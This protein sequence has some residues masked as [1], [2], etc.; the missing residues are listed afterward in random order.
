MIA[1]G[2]SSASTGNG[3]IP[4]NEVVTKLLNEL[5]TSNGPGLQY[6]VVDKGSIIFEHS[7]GLSD[8]EQKKPL[9]LSQTM[10]AFSMTKTLTAIAVLQLIEHKKINID[11]PV[12]EYFKHPYNAE[13]TI[14]QLLNHTSGIPNPIP[15]KWVHLAENHDIFDEQKALTQVLKENPYSDSLP[16]TEYKY[17]NIGYWL[18]GKVIEKASGKK[19]VDYVTENIFVLLGLTSDEIGFLIKSMNNHAKGYVKKWSFMNLIGRFL[20]DGSVFGNDEGGWIHTKNVYLNGPSFGGTV[21]SARAFSRIL[22]DL[23]SEKSEL[24]GASVKQMLYSQQKVESGKKIDMT[25]GWH[26]GQ[27]NNLTYYYKEG[28]G[29]GFSS[30]MRIY[31]ESGLASVLM[32]NRTSFNFKKNM[33]KLDKNFVAN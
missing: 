27:L 14:R 16:G 23:L 8:V 3:T 29:A 28:G 24:L 18:L 26:I 17:S 1:V 20:I 21:G 25:L 12:L 4:K 15:L 30:E 9:R 33:S 11:D 7:T 22:Q 13:I 19:Y 31:S 10:A 2:C 32:T 5:S 6:I